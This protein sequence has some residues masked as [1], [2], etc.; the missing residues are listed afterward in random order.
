M[1]VA[2]LYKDVLYI[3]IVKGHWKFVIFN[4]FDRNLA[5]FEN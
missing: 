3:E 4:E 1:P 5:L 2:Q